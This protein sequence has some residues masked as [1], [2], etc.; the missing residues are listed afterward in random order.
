MLGGK[1]TGYRA[2]AEEVT[3]AVC[4]RL[5]AR[6]RRSTTADMPLPGA[7]PVVPVRTF[8]ATVTPH[9]YDLFGTRA[10]E[11]RM[12]LA[13][14]RSELEQ[15]LSPTYPDIAAQVVFAVQVRALPSP[16]GL[17]A[18]AYAARGVRRIRVERG[19]AGSRAHG[20]AS[21][22]GPPRGSPRR[23]M[24]TVATSR[25][26]WHSETL[27]KPVSTSLVTL[28]LGVIGMTGANPAQDPR[29]APRRV[30]LRAGTHARG[31]SARA[32]AGSGL[33][34]AGPADLEGRRAGLPARSDARAHDQRRGRVSRSSDRRTRRG[35]RAWHV[36]DFTLAR[37][38]DASTQDRWFDP[39]FAGERIPTFQEAID[40]VRGKA[41][42][43][44]ETKGPEVYG[45]RGLRHGALVLAAAGEERGS[46]GRSPIRRRRSSSSRS[47]RRACRR[48]KKAGTTLPLTFLVSDLDSAARPLADR[49][50]AERGPRRSPPVSVRP[51]RCCWPTRRLPARVRAAGLT[52]TPYTF[53]SVGHARQARRSRT[54][55]PSSSTASASTRCSPTTLISSRD[56][57]ASV[58]RNELQHA[59]G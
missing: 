20:G 28:S 1:I 41:G 55:W 5:G 56:D 22:G 25:P 2:I 18:P 12:A 19:R 35:E 39:K 24:R 57:S 29:R 9:L 14:S 11:R 52:L 48:C 23:S 26:R 47:R 36:S 38:E 59:P 34:R 13:R 50:G 15:P 10:A 8:A 33:R 58:L 54:R 30:R 49:R 27:M 45:S 4:R 37:A 7:R 46:T 44:P 40:L 43:Y 42:L 51:S 31:L 32:R 16:V 21:S 6:D 3:D 53:R 17:P